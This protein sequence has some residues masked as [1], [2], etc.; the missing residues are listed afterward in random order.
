[1]SGQD[2]SDVLAVCKIHDCVQTS[3]IGDGC[4]VSIRYD[5]E[6]GVYEGDFSRGFMPPTHG[7]RGTSSQ[8][9]TW[10]NEQFGNDLIFV[11]V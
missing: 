1:M 3:E 8:V 6:D 2:Y 4:S 9:S 11:P 10:L 5:A 7:T